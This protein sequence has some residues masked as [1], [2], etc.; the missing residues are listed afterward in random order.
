[1]EKRVFQEGHKNGVILSLSDLED[2]T[3]HPDM[4]YGMGHGFG[5]GEVGGDM[6]Y[7]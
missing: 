1:M 6:L 5:D 7:L 3:Q 4:E 2:V